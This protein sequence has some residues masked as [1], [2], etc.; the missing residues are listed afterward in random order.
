MNINAEFH[1]H[2]TVSDGTLSPSEIIKLAKEKNLSLIALTDHDTTEGILEAAEMAKKLSV[3]FIPGIELSCEHKGSTV[4]VLGFFKGDYF[5]N[6]E[7]QDFLHNLKNSRIN[8]AKEIVNRLDKFFN[9]K[10]N[11]EDVLKKGKG[12][13]ARPHIAQC[14]L[15]AGYDYDQDYIFDNFIGN[16]SPAYVPNKKITV[17][18][19]INL[20]KKYNALVFL[21]HPKLLKNIKLDEICQF[22]FDGLEAIYFQNTPIENKFYLSYCRKNNLLITCGSDSHGNL[23]GDTRHGSI[24][25]MTLDNYDFNNF[26]KKYNL[27]KP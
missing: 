26:L 19:G 10:I 2:S 9:I 15:E 21:A 14:I 22:N 25:D 12:V 1:C 7:F 11:Y 4:H 18:D 17:E 27:L 23:P 13:V 20:L 8:R 5:K 3:N 16:N 6:K 24:G